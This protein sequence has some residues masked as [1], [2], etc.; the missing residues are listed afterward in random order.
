M[1]KPKTKVTEEMKEQFLVY[2]VQH[3]RIEDIA[4]KIGV[5]RRTGYRI[6]EE[7]VKE[8]RVKQ[9]GFQYPGFFVRDDPG[10][11]PGT[12]GGACDT[13]QVGNV[14]SEAHISGTFSVAV[15]QEGDREDIRDSRGICYGYWAKDPK[16]PNGSV[17]Y[18][19]DIRLSPTE[20]K[21]ILRYRKGNRGSMSLR[22]NPGRI[23]LDPLLYETPEQVI[24]EFVQ[25]AKA[26]FKVL[27]THG[28]VFSE[29][30]KLAGKIHFAWPGH[31]WGDYLDRVYKIDD[32]QIVA[33]HS[34]GKLEVEIEN[35]ET[36]DGLSN[37]QILAH[38]PAHI[39]ALHQQNDETEVSIFA[40][41]EKNRQMQILMDGILDNIKTV[42]EIF[43]EQQRIQSEQFLPYRS[44]DSGKEGYQ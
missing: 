25:R 44:R 23:P 35:G 42:G 1:S 21:T 33:D 36:D 18:T 16:H 13:I 34:N 41:Q 2:L 26:V 31:P 40:L 17:E 20:T 6:K 12:G 19:A 30:F 37:A 11:A 28:W 24:N 3:M 4:R 8:G 10:E 32:D 29:E 38:A 7:L 9:F 5:S 43:I 22:I 27:R 15:L 39:E 14:L